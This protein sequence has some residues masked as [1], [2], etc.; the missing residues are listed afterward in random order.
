MKRWKTW[1]RWA[2]FS[3]RPGE[4]GSWIK[5]SNYEGV[6]SPVVVVLESDYRK[7]MK[8]YRA[9]VKRTYF[10]Q[11]LGEQLKARKALEKAVS[12]AEGEK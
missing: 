1:K 3:N 11:D 9:A 8:V 7:I 5:T 2:N 4:I 12:Q 10:Y 6:D